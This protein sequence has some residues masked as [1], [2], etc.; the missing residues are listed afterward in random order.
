MQNVSDAGELVVSHGG[1]EC[2]FDFAPASAN[3][4]KLQWAAM[5]GNCLHEVKEVTKG[6]RAT[7]TFSILQE[8][9]YI[10]AS[11][12]N[13]AEQDFRITLDNGF[14]HNCP[15]MKVGC[16]APKVLVIPRG[17]SVRIGTHEIS[18]RVQSPF[19]ELCA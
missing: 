13:V 15:E 3:T 1:V 4:T 16:P 11:P 12:D 7:I 14:R 18:T 8:E 19:T 2:V 6:Y 9:G 17:L 5:Y 10:R